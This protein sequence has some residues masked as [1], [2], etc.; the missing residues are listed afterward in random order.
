MAEQHRLEHR[1]GERGAV[2]RDERPV[3]ARRSRVDRAGEDFLAGAGGAVDEDGDV[4]CSNPLGKRQQRQALGVGGNRGTRAAQD[5]AGETVADRSVIA[6][7]GKAGR[8]AVGEGS[9]LRLAGADDHCARGRRGHFA[10]RDQIE[11]ARGRF[12]VFARYDREALRPQSRDQG[13]F[14]PEHGG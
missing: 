8:I 2:D 11:I 7:I 12:T 14:L 9:R 1:F 10:F 13:V 6:V 5:R 3:L 4:G